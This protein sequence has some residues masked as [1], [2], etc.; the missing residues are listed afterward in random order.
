M[1]HVSLIFRYSSIL[2]INQNSGPTKSIKLSYHNKFSYLNRELFKGQLSNIVLYK[3]PYY[4]I[5]IVVMN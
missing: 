2:G 5:S 3:S 4:N 1:V